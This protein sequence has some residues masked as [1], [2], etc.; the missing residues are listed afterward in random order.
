MVASSWDSAEDPSASTRGRATTR[1]VA[2]AAVNSTLSRLEC[3]MT[4]VPRPQTWAILFSQSGGECQSL[5]RRPG[6]IANHPAADYCLESAGRNTARQLKRHRT[7]PIGNASF[8]VAIH[9]L[10][11]V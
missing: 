9:V 2:F 8:A 7:L 4:R 3:E 10:C 6:G 1:R 5:S 11:I